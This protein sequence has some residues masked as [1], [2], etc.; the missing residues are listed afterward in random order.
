MG[1]PILCLVK[2]FCLFLLLLFAQL[3]SAQSAATDPAVLTAPR[4][5]KKVSG[6]VVRLRASEV[7][8]IEKLAD[9]LLA[10]LLQANHRA[11]VN[12]AREL[13]RRY[14]L[15]DRVIVRGDSGRDVR[16]VANA[17]VKK[18]YIDSEDVI[19]TFDRGALLD[20]ELYDALLRFQKDKK[21]PVD[22]RVTKDVVKEL[23][24]RK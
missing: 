8:D 7:A 23:R 18:L 13:A 4:T 21:L 3:A 22:G 14:K 1:C 6:N 19:P 9:R 20:G 17:L 16:S 12:A 15:G 10:R 5:Y 2:R 24:K 11:R